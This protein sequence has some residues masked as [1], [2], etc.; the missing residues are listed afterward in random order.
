MVK[1]IINIVC[2]PILYNILEEIKDNLSFKVSNFNNEDEF[3]KFLNENKTDYKKFFIITTI[4]KKDFFFKK[5]FNLKNIFFFLKHN[6]EQN[7][8]SNYNIF[9]Y[10][11]D[12]YN[13]IEKIN[14]QLIKQK[15]DF[16]SKIKLKNYYLDLNSRTIT[17]NNINLKLTEREMDIILFLNDS[18]KPQKINVLQNQVWKHLSKLETHTVETHIYRLRK[19]M[20]D[21]FKDDNFIVSSDA[22]YFIK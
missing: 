15:Y 2:I 11:V 21:N 22:G 4:Q 20:N 19:K 6:G 17:K 3:L 16:Q 10:P 9:K 14:I 7:F 5:N 18:E 8:D 13:L 1:Q 12:I